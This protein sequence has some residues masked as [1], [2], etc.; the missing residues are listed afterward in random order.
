MATKNQGDGEKGTTSQRS[1]GDS[2]ALRLQNTDHPGMGLV[3][4]PLD[5]TNYLS[6]SRAVRLAL[7]A[8]QNLS[9]MDG[10]SL[11]SAAGSDELEQWQ[12]TDCMVISWLLN[13]ISKE[14]VEAF[15]YVPSARDL[16]VDLED[17]FGESNKPFL[18]QI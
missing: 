9:F 5:G 1:Q 17:R 2:D 10:K 3:S 13:S 8:K 4:V 6:C 12:R 14:I 15:T 11:K 7:G 16:W 18:Y